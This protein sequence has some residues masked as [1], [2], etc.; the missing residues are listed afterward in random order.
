[1]NRYIIF[2]SDVDDV[3]GN[4]VNNQN[5]PGK[6]QNGSRTTGVQAS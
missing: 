2:L 5:L 3:N 1:M 6:E 4:I